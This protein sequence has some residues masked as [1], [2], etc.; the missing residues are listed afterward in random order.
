M[1]TDGRVASAQQWLSCYSNYPEY[2]PHI[3]LPMILQE[4]PQFLW[5]FLI[6]SVYAS[7]H[8]K[9]FQNETGKSTPHHISILLST[10]LSFL[11]FQKDASS[12]VSD[13]GSSHSE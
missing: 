6:L 1:S 12:I 8:L 3:L 10:L 9:T 11:G 4:S 7:P 5:L 2:L 13:V